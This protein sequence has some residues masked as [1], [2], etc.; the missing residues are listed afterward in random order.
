MITAINKIGSAQAKPTEDVEAAVLRFLN[1]AKRW[2]N[3]QLVYKASNMQL[4]C[5]SDASYL[6]ETLARSR[7]G[8]I[9]FLG[10]NTE[11]PYINGA[12]EHMSCMIPCTV[13]SAAEAEYAALFL[14]AQVAEGFRNTLHDLGYPQSPTPIICDNACAVAITNN[15]VKQKRSKAID[16][17]FHWVRDRVQQ[18][19][20]IVSWRPGTE[21]LA[22][23]FT[24]AHSVKHHMAM[25]IL[26]VSDSLPEVIRQ[27]SRARYIARRLNQKPP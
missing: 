14:V 21:N 7:A 17:R 13:A 24:K 8:G 23:F 6:S 22:D 26:Y 1:Y 25:R 11:A 9:L 5:H 20:F 10:T 2:P 3:A 27:C 4:T 12:I 18:G 15:T 16:M 19:H